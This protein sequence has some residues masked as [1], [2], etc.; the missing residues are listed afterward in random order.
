MQACDGD[1][2]CNNA[3]FFKLADE[4][5]AELSVC[6][7]D[8][9]CIATPSLGNASCPDLSGARLAAGFNASWLAEVGTMYVVGG[10]NAVYDCFD[11]QVSLG[12]LFLLCVC[13]CVCAL[14][15]VGGGGGGGAWCTLAVLAAVPARRELSVITRGRQ[16]GSPAQA[17]PECTQARSTRT[18]ARTLGA[19]A[20]TPSAICRHPPPA[21]CCTLCRR[22]SFLRR[23]GAAW[24]PRGA[25]PWTAKSATRHTP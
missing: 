9:G 8:A 10:A 22:W 6:A 14:V 16:A 19:A 12:V 17:G 5:Y 1:A 11:C 20:L 4:P 7:V 15:V 23:R 13:V 24:T 18:C 3:C 2:A 21:P 25:R